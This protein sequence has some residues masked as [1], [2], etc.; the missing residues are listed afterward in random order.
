MIDVYYS[1]LDNVVSEMK[2]R[3]SNLDLK[4]LSLC[5]SVIQGD[6]SW[7]KH[8]DSIRL[9]KCWSRYLFSWSKDFWQHWKYTWIE[10]F[11]HNNSISWDQYTIT[12]IAPYKWT[13]QDFFFYSCNLLLRREIIFLN[14][15]AKNLC[16]IIHRVD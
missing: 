9:L 3:F 6:S 10:D 7:E 8:Q 15:R 14:K 16:K 2:E 12:K 4:I 1:A 11:M 5:V 13:G